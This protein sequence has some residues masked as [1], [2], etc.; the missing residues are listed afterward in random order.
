MQYF[1]PSIPSGSVTVHVSIT[2]ASPINIEPSWYIEL[3]CTHLPTC[4]Q[5][6]L[7]G[8]ICS[9]GFAG[10]N[11]SQVVTL[12]TGL[13]EVLSHGPGPN[14]SADYLARMGHTM[15]HGPGVLLVYA[16]YSLAYG[17][18]NDLQSYN[19]STNTWS[20]VEV[21]QLESSI[22]SARYLQSAVFYNVSIS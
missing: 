22:P 17:L 3:H 18:L 5:Q 9:V 21:N 8:C 13:W 1:L 10:P 20:L 16:G 4:R 7:G 14:I 19:L 11:C 15:V 12:A 2:H 6:T